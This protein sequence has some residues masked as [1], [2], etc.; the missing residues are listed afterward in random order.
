MST[1]TVETLAPR[2][3]R[4]GQTK[5]HHNGNPPSSFKNP[6]PSVGKPNSPLTMLQARFGGERTF[7]PVPTA[8]DGA[9]S[10]EL[11]KVR[12]PDWGVDRKDRLRATWLGHAG[13]LIEFPAAPGAERGIRI[14]C[15]PVF[16]ERTSPVQFFGPKRY[17]PP[18]IPL[19]ELPDVDV[20]CISHDHYDHL[21]F[22]TVQHL[23][24][25]RKGHLHFI[26]GLNNKAWFMQHL[27]CATDEV[28]DADWWDSFEIRSEKFGSVTMTC[29]PTQHFSGRAPLS[30]G[31]TLWCSWAF[32]AAG[33]KL[34]FA[35]DTAYQAN[36]TPSPCPAFVE[37]GET[38]GPFDLAMV[39]IGLMTPQK[40]MGG[41]HATPE[42]SIHIHREVRSKLS[43]G[44]HYGTVRGGISAHY[45]DVRDPP[46]RWREAAEK[47]GI[48]CGGGI[49]GNGVAI[50][51]KKEGVG[52]CDVGL[53]CK[54]STAWV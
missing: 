29:C 33:R 49:E 21:D 8:Q 1:V 31:H 44:M 3:P 30:M 13:F 38:L 47:E 37:I 32:E 45:E 26:A 43:I 18:P 15:D 19:D 52:L 34:Y 17:T 20:I 22:A 11:V 28:T 39:P 12:R 54:Q 35:G 50:D 23:Y 27:G 14:L 48:W 40:I 24:N 2:S 36:D 10:E 42:Q 7:V 41:V 51:V 53:C 25:K 4:K 5:N 6:W 46:R 16:S 9:R